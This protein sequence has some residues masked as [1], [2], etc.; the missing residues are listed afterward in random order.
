MSQTHPGNNKIQSILTMQKQCE[1]CNTK[2]K[3][4]DF[5]ISSDNKTVCAHCISEEIKHAKKGYKIQLQPP[6]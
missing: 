2:I 5:Y 1:K 4:Q 6:P 3:D